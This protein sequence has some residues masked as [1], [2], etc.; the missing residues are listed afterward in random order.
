M[1]LRGI[2]AI[3]LAL[4]WG[5]AFAQVNQG[6]TPLSGSKGG[7]N[8]A[9]MQF[10]GPATSLKTYTLPNANSTLAALGAIQTWTGAQSFTDG[11]LILLGSGSGS[12]TIKAPATG[13]GTATLFAGSDTIAGI[14]VTQVLTNKTINCANNTCTVRIGTDVS[15]LGTGVATA[16]ANGINTAGGVVVPTAAL[17]ANGV[18]YGGG[19]GVT[20]GSTAAGTNGQVF[21]GVTAGAPQW[22]TMS[23]DVSITNA[24]VATIAANAVTNAKMA[25]MN[26]WT[27]KVNDTSGG[28]T[29]TDQT[30]DGQTLKASPAAGDELWLWDVAGVALKKTTVS[31]VA[32]SGLGT[33]VATALAAN[34]SAAGGVTS[35]IASG[36]TAMGTGAISSSTCATV[37]TATATNT[38]TTD[39]VSASFN[40]DPTAVTGYVPLTTGMLTIIVY[41]TTNNVNFKVCNNTTASITPG[42]VTLNWRVVR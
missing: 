18:V 37:V 2:I 7:T 29:P 41:P 8:N 42:A 30:I 6:T 20:P 11:T 3:G 23:G 40:G 35:T 16:L 31:A 38:A 27:F 34:L 28:A 26:A 17:T 13:G 14:A 15:G 19:S 22:A 21:L 9:F 39:V 24:G 4:A 36:S 12:S 33:G 10:T 1:K 32:S 5:P 25:T